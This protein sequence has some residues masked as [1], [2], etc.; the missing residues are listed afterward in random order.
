LRAFVGRGLLESFE[1]K[2][3][4][5]YQ[6]SGFSV[7]VGVCVEADR[8]GLERLLRYCACPAFS[9]VRL[10]KAGSV[11]VYRC[12][13]QHS[14]LRSD[15]IRGT[16]ADEL[17]LTCLEL[18]DRVVALMPPP[19]THQPMAAAPA[20]ISAALVGSAAQSG[21]HPG[22]KGNGALASAQQVHVLAPACVPV[23][24]PAP[25]K[26]AANYLWAVPIERIYEVFPL[27]CPLSGGQ[28]HIIAFTTHSAD[29]RQIMDH[30]GIDSDL[31]HIAPARGRTLWDGVSAPEDVGVE[32]WPSGM[33]RHSR[34][35][36]LRL[37]TASVGDTVKRRFRQLWGATAC[38]QDPNPYCI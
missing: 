12:A 11:L 32:A 13:K 36:K 30:I 7:D 3:M 33:S 15:Y 17:H 25:P 23:Q 10:R 35:Q 9:R 16:N 38:S 5:G 34:H 24:T 2:E 37:I 14:E 29:I 18:I 8:T 19:R 4:L 31:L 26:R 20:L 22:V 21:T 1:V 6:H 28:M 27:V